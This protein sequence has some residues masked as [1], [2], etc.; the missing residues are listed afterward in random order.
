METCQSNYD[1][2]LENAQR[3]EPSQKLALIEAL[4]K[5]IPNETVEEQ[6]LQEAYSQNNA[7]D[8]QEIANNPANVSQVSVNQEK[9]K[10]SIWQAVH[11]RILKTSANIRHDY[12]QI[13]NDDWVVT[14]IDTGI[15][16]ISIA[17][18]AIAITIVAFLPQSQ[19]IAA[20]PGGVAFL[21]T[22]LLAIVSSISA[23]W[24]LIHYILQEI[25]ER[26]RLSRITRFFLY[27]FTELQ[28]IPYIA[29]I[30]CMVCLVILSFFLLPLVLNQP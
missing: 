13:G 4:A 25:L 20:L 9:R 24:L 21:S 16:E 26:W 15:V 6:P 7:E 28:L 30:F 14:K 2:L 17:L 23:L 3:L 10:F 12:S 19:A 29:L 5:S 11:A 22:G 18:A 27:F 1:S 8:I